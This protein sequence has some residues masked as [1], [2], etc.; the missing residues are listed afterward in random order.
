M[1]FKFVIQCIQYWEWSFLF[2]LRSIKFEFEF[3]SIMRPAVNMTTRSRFVK[4]SLRSENVLWIFRQ[5]RPPGY[6]MWH[7]ICHTTQ[8]PVSSLSWLINSSSFHRAAGPAKHCIY[9]ADVVIIPN[10]ISPEFCAIWWAIASSITFLCNSVG[11][12]KELDSIQGRRKTHA[13]INYQEGGVWGGR[14]WFNPLYASFFN[15]TFCYLGLL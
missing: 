15:V 11:D 8:T 6:R 10:N 2:G 3:E 1:I 5:S 14:G 9:Q 13:A 7:P 12:L 4:R